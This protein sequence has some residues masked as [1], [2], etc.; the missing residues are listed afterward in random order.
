MKKILFITFG[1][2][3]SALIF[4]QS[5]QAF[6][7]QGVARDLSGDP[8]TN[9]NIGLRIAVLQGSASGME[10]YKE[11]HNTATSDLG[12]FSLQIGTGSV[13]N[14]DFEMID[15]GIESHFL[16]IELD[17][18]GGSNYQVI[19]TNEL[20]S[21]PYALYAEQAGN[22]TWESNNNYIYT[23]KKVSIGSA[24]PDRDAGLT[25]HINS[26]GGNGRQ[27]V[28]SR[29]LSNDFSSLNQFILSSGTEENEALGF[30]AAHANSYTGL[31][32]YNGYI[33]LAGANKS[34]GL[35]LRA[36]N[37]DGDIKFVTGGQS[38][39]NERLNLNADGLLK[40]RSGDIYIEDID[41]GVIM[42]SP[43][44]QCWRMTVNNSGQPEYNSINC[45]N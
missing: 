31:F 40:L 2:L 45:P 17:E 21:V 10:V 11:T 34:K 26:N 44:G 28:R 12:I 36:T 32:G 15:W 6:N 8:I 9:Q 29:N 14:G 25:I 18:N 7:Y 24:E 30:L 4:G 33:M 20:L 3:I 16:Q 43:N 38:L 39:S 41:S 35:I 22:S 27:A 1:V 23:T 42:K 19:G 37:P 13:V 5:P